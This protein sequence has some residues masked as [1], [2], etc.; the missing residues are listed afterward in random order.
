[1]KKFRLS[2]LTICLMAFIFP[3][4]LQAFRF[5]DLVDYA[6]PAISFCILTACESP[7]AAAFNTKNHFESLKKINF[8]IIR[9]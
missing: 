9:I 8:Y 5:R 3:S 7:W 4:N 2:F 1:M 6:V